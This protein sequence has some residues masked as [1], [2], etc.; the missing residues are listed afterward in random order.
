M[1]EPAVEAHQQSEVEENMAALRACASDVAAAMARRVKAVVAPDG[2]VTPPA[3]SKLCHFIRHGEGFHNVA[4]REW[5][6]D[7]Q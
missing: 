6:A 5:R 1:S 3:G 4:Q 2:C 7:P